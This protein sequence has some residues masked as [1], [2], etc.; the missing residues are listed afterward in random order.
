MKEEDQHFS[1]NVSQVSLSVIPNTIKSVSTNI[2]GTKQSCAVA[3]ETSTSTPLSYANPLSP[4]M[5]RPLQADVRKQLSRSL[6][7]VTVN[8]LVLVAISTWAMA[9]VGNVW[10]WIQGVVFW[11]VAGIIIYTQHFRGQSA[12][13]GTTCCQLEKPDSSE[14]SD[15]MIDPQ[16]EFHIQM[17][18]SPIHFFNIFRMYGVLFLMYVI[19]AF[20]IMAVD[21][22]VFQKDWFITS[23]IPLSNFQLVNSTSI[24]FTTV[25]T[26]P[27]NVRD[28]ISGMADEGQAMFWI[29]AVFTI[30]GTFTLYRAMNMHLQALQWLEYINRGRNAT[31][32]ENDNKA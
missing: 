27:H 23:V 32:L 28:T 10:L 25:V 16:T 31:I 29:T 3:M 14:S 17:R 18:S 6:W 11:I 4:F 13:F 30:I 21:M 15:I 8:A 1:S 7:I 5:V 20:S 26:P 9:S 12:M 24:S 19:S 2:Q 22:I